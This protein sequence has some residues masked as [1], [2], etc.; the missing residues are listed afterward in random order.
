M[1]LL[2]EQEEGKNFCLICIFI[3]FHIEGILS[4]LPV[5]TTDKVCIAV[6]TFLFQRQ[7]HPYV[8]YWCHRN[9]SHGQVSLEP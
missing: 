2:V 5:R 7:P 8:L 3:C 9:R 6:C 4:S 1:I